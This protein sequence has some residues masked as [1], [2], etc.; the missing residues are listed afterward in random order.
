LF[1]DGSD[2]RAGNLVVR[3]LAP[4]GKR[5]PAGAA[6]CARGKTAGNKFLLSERRRRSRHRRGDLEI[7]RRAT[8]RQSPDYLVVCRAS[9]CSKSGPENLSALTSQISRLPGAG[10]SDSCGQTVGG[11]V[12]F[13]KDG[14]C[15]DEIRIRSQR[16]GGTLIL[17]DLPCKG[18]LQVSR[19]PDWRQPSRVGARGKAGLVCRS[20][21]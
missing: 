18:V 4:K 9:A 2:G 6:A 12:S 7:A 15:S 3:Q 13:A 20:G 16:L 10:L 19:H 5:P 11:A 1:V 14:T 8:A 21:R 17:V